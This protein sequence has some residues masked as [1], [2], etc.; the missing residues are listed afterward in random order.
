MDLPKEERWD[1]RVCPDRFRPDD[2]ENFA[3]EDNIY[4]RK[5]WKKAFDLQWHTEQ[6]VRCSGVMMTDSGA[7]L[8]HWIYRSWSWILHPIGNIGCNAPRRFARRP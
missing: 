4:Y 1:A 2:Q 7:L 8:T 3:P 6:K 5:S